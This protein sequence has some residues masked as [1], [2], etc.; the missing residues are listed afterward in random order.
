MRIDREFQSFDRAIV[1]ATASNHSES[2]GAQCGWGGRPHGVVDK[3]QLL[4]DGHITRDSLSA[5]C[6]ALG[7]RQQPVYSG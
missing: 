6:I 4:V 7:F 3:I 2:G 5:A 1:F